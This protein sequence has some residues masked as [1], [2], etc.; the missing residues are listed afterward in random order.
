M[1]LERV[2]KTS[3]VFRRCL[4]VFALMPLM[5]VRSSSASSCFEVSVCKAYSD[6]SITLI[7]HGQV[8]DVGVLPPSAATPQAFSA[9]QERN[10]VRFLVREVLK[11]DPTVQQI[12]LTAA[13]G[14]YQV[15]HE[16]LVYVGESGSSNERFA[17]SCVHQQDT[18]NAY[19]NSSDLKLL[20]F[21]SSANGSGAIFGRLYLGGTNLGGDQAPLAEAKVAMSIS[22]P[23]TREIQAEHGDH[24]QA[25]LFTSV[26]P[27]NYMVTAKAAPGVAVA[28]VSGEGESV[29]VTANSCQDVDWFLR[30]DNHIRGQVRDEAGRPL[31]GVDVGLFK[32]GVQ[33]DDLERGRFAQFA[34]AVTNADGRYDFPGTNPGEYSVVLHPHPATISSPYPPVF[35]PAAAMPAEA[36]VLHLGTGETLEGIDL[37]RSPALR[38][39]TVHLSVRRANGTA[40]EHASVIVSDPASSIAIAATGRTD[41]DGSLT[42]SLFAQRS[43][44]VTASTPDPIGETQESPQCA[45]P[46]EFVAADGMNLAP[47]IPDKTFDACRSPVRTGP[48]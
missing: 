46:V 22:G 9:V 45:G 36:K 37:V 14:I 1:Q 7:F 13:K 25:Y 29:S 48:A 35:Y 6:A 16:Y 17:R 31:A 8:I 34:R 27:G 40:I 24:E 20:R 32:R 11:G 10:T 21:L 41:A 12:T 33:E 15:G 44:R 39:A 38:P 2:A 43:Y 3:L 19:G 42:V 26:P 5:L 28:P 30:V 4:V 23:I 47:L 18:S